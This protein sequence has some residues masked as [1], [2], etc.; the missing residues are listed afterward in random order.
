MKGLVAIQSAHS[1]VT[2]HIPVPSI[3]YL[4]ILPELIML[5]GALLLLG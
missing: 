2:T 5:G 4:A 3:T 1:A